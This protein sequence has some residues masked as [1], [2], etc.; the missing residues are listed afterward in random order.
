MKEI[1]KSDAQVVLEHLGYRAK[2]SQNKECWELMLACLCGCPNCGIE[3]KVVFGGVGATA[4]E[5]SLWELA[6]KSL[7]SS[8]KLFSLAVLNQWG[9][10][11]NKETRGTGLSVRATIFD[12]KTAK[13][14]WGVRSTGNSFAECF[15]SSLACAI[16][17]I[18][19]GGYP[20]KNGDCES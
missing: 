7:L 19:G 17:L 8:D 1:A 18:D 14:V 11:S 5:E 10:E 15:I 9:Y 3:K 20:R 4:T 6:G 16:A 13:A 12:K 2:E